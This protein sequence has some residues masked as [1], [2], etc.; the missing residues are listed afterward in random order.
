MLNGTQGEAMPEQPPYKSFPF[1]TPRP[2]GAPLA[3]AG[4]R[5]LDFTRYLAGPWCTQTLADMG[6]EV[7]KIEAVG[8]GDETRSFQP[9]DVDGEAP[10]FIG[11]NRNKKS[12]CLNLASQGGVSV[13]MDLVAAADV[14]VENF[15]PGVMSRLGLDYDSLKA[16]RPD[17]IYCA[18]TAYGSDSSY[19][20][21]PGFDSVFQA[22]SGFASLTGEPDRLPMRTG[23]PVVDIATSMNA[24]SAVLGALV[25]RERLGVGQ[26]VEVSMFDTAVTLLGY[27]PMNY[28]ASGEDPVRQGN[29]APV[30]TPI[31]MFETAEGGAIYVSCGSQRSWVALA[32]HVLDR[33]DLVEH[34]DYADNR[35]RN[36]NR[37]AL[38]GLIAEIF[39]SR[40]RDHWLR[41][42]FEG[43]VPI[44]AVR[45]VGEALDAPLAR[46]RSLVT[47]IARDEGGEVPNIAS[48]FRFS[49]TP[50]AEPVPAPRLNADAET[51]L[52]GMLGY[53]AARLDALSESGAFDAPQKTD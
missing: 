37:D 40:P 32:E 25:A 53:D 22:E 50:V 24:T 39:L 20:G 5:I 29:T 18:I 1:H 23:S 11:L 52:K 8:T 31:G 12:L 15:S 38:M 45:T 51:V 13:V 41:K 3:L 16:V 19:A 47:R 36:R 49:E 35:A 46:E 34:P 2:S 17:L 30:A 28:L 48:P 27:Q 4:L 43:R 42:A 10:Y 7:I 33:P 21:Q 26:Y 9:P 14:I 44:G 6:A